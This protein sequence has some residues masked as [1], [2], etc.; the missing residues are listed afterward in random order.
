[1]VPGR[2]RSGR[3]WERQHSVNALDNGSIFKQIG[4]LGAPICVSRS[5]LWDQAI[6]GQS[7]HQKSKDQH[8]IV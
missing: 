4:A 7:I 8:P 1:M 5:L 2:L 6:N 3:S